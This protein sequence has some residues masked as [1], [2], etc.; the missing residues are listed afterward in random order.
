MNFAI[1]FFSNVTSGLTL[2][3]YYKLNLTYPRK[4]YIKHEF[5]RIA[6]I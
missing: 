6:N 4:R 1:D 5:A 3:T 2:K